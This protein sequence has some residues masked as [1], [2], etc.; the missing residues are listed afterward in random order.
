MHVGIRQ[1]T[2]QDADWIADIW[3]GVIADTLATFTTVPKTGAEVAELI[4]TQPVFVAPDHAGFATFGPFRGGPGYAATAEHT[5][6]VAPD[7][8]GQGHGAHLMAA[9]LDHAQATGLRVMVA[10]I[11][12]AN[13]GAVRFHARL[14]FAQVG[15][16][17]HVGRKAGQWLDLI[18]MQKRINPPD[19]SDAQG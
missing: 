14:G 7:R 5:V 4:A 6:Y 9:L 15:H 12:G 2:A 13:P 11:S 16:M 18:L 10:A 19:S 1:A 17:P 3:N 8:C